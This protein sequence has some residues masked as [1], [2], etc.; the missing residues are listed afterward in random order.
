MIK[1]TIGSPLEA[2]CRLMVIYLLLESRWT[3]LLA[4]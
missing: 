4:K 2:K 3:G 1:L